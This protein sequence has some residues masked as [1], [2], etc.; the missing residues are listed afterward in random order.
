VATTLANLIARMEGWLVPGSLA[1]VNN[2][3]GNLR[4]VGQAGTTGSY[5]GYATFSTP[6]AGW[7]ALERQLRLDAA[8]G[9]T[10]AT[11]INSYAP[12]SEND[13]GNYLR[14]LVAGLGVPASTPLT[15]VLGQPAAQVSPSVSLPP[16]YGG[17]T[18]D[19][20]GEIPYDTAGVLGDLGQIPW[21]V[22]L[23]MAGGVGLLVFMRRD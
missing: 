23:A 9:D 20:T 16:D 11:F 3:P 15:S 19:F 18:T 17:V 1:Q 6:E 8:A 10:V 21:W 12:P 7:S 2:N 14:F 4:Y 13:T 5:K 22:W